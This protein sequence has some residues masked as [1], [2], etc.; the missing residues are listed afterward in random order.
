MAIINKD[1]MN[2][3]NKQELIEIAQKEGKVRGVVFYTDAAYVRRHEGEEALRGIEEETKKMGYPIDYSEMK[4]PAWY[5]VG[6]R[7]VSLLAIKKVL[8]WDDEQI[9]EM[10]RSA[11]KY[12]IIT[13]LLLRYFARPRAIENKLGTYWRKHYSVGSLEGRITSQLSGIV[14]LKDF[15]THPILCTYLKGYFISLLGMIVGVSEQLSIEETKCMHRGDEYH[16]FV[17]KMKSAFKIIK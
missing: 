6:L 8:N 7:A 11:P 15:Q 4:P 16:E 3:M 5:P 2:V 17:F 10:G 1:I 9:K 12:S 14:H 13:K